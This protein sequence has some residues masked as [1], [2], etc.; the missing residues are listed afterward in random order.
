VA[1]AGLALLGALG[2]SIPGSADPAL[3]AWTW[4]HWGLCA[5]LYLLLVNDPPPA[6]GLGRLFGLV[7]VA[8]A[9]V[10]VVQAAAQNTGLLAQLP[11]RWP[12]ALSAETRGASVAVD[13][14]GTR[15]LRAY[16][17]LP[18]PNIL[19]GMLL[20]FLGAPVER[21]LTT[22][23]RRWPVV[24]ALG[25]VALGLTL[26]RAAWLGLL[27]GAAVLAWLAPAAARRRL[28]LAVGLGLLALASVLVPLAPW[29]LPRLGAG[30]GNALERA[31]ALERTLLIG[32]S[33]EAWRAQPLTGVGLGAF[34]Q[35]AA[36]STGVGLPFE[37][38][39]NLPL[40]VLAETG[41]VGAAAALLLVGAWA[42]LVWRRRGAMSVGEVVW[43]AVMAAMLGMGLFDH[44]GWTQ[45]PARTLA[46]MALAT[47]ARLAAGPE[48]ERAA[49]GEAFS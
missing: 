7:V 10:A 38:V 21:W 27:A 16:G 23:R 34:V 13:A 45:A 17:T 29:V 40:L 9:L 36:R 6:A 30:G 11:L 26:S 43:A 2:L 22:G 18:H 20:A 3:S 12:G 14:L 19:G 35:W 49:P 8:Q 33:L 39:H 47:W 25:I 1:L 24:L 41:L 32:Y 46:V 5:G 48:P 37:P 31:S 15:W 44:A 4:L 42:G 28:R